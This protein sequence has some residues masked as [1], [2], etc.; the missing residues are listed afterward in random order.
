M[1][2]KTKNTMKNIQIDYDL[3][4]RIQPVGGV[5][6]GDERVVKVGQNYEAC[7]HIYDYPQ[8]LKP[9]WLCTLLNINNVVATLDIHTESPE[10][11]KSNIDKSTSEQGS[12][13]N[14][15]KNLTEV[16]D[17]Q[18]KMA[19]LDHLYQKIQDMGEVVKSVDIRL[20]ISAP[21]LYELDQKIA[22]VSSHL[23]KY[24]YKSTIYLNENA[25]E[26]KS[27][28]RSYTKQQKLATFKRL[29]QPLES[30]CLGAGDPFHFSALND[31]YGSYYGKTTSGGQVLFYPFTKTD[32]RTHYNCLTIGNM[33][34]GKSTFLKKMLSDLACR[35]DYIRGFDKANEYT[36][37]INELGGKII[38][39]DGSAGVIN[40]LE[41]FS[42]G[43]TSEENAFKTHI[44]KLCTIYKYLSPSAD[45]YELAAFENV[46]VE[47][48]EAYGLIDSAHME[49]LQITGLPPE[50]Y[51]IW[52]DFELFLTS[53]IK[54]MSDKGFANDL[55]LD[56]AKKLDNIRIIITTLS[57]TYAHIFN[58]HTCIENVLDE[59]IVF[60]DI[61]NLS[62][63]RS[64]IFDLQIFI[65]LSLFWDN[66]TKV[67][68]KMKD[69]YDNNKIAFEDITRFM[70]FM[71][72]AS[73]IININKMQAVEQ[74]TAYAREAR[75]FFGGMIFALQSIRDVVPENAVS[76]DES[77]KNTDEIIKLYEFCQYK[78]MFQQDNN[79]IDLLN[80]IFKHQL[81]SSE[82]KQIPT[83][84][85]G[86]CI[87]AIQ[88]D[89]NIQ[90]KIE[91][92]DKEKRLFKGGA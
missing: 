35:G 37:L 73:N 69:L 50:K 15:A 45:K 25:D 2:S 26:Y 42:T 22:D 30:E 77:R 31:E 12:R 76:N 75:K 51:P 52:S 39:L 49:H 85:I 10:S 81:T 18:K 70:I 56:Y 87:L 27:M 36:D 46:I 79:T 6:F 62:K 48:Y 3:I 9:F 86:E 82:I 16:R 24:D 84:K 60:F 59:Q 32:S 19:E 4:R 43:E 88:G 63:M 13:A 8:K 55:E 29:G 89:E 54:K 14:S 44:S 91:I 33:G 80:K 34:K 68:A 78:I 11:V 23:S 5:S 64:E 58:K 65:A 92:T 20:F 90:F 74:L 57:Q 38:S 40:A 28:Y 17:A 1:F 66:C 47:F 7:L 53:K 83:L 71:D 61:K 72:E 67:G 41:V 21:T